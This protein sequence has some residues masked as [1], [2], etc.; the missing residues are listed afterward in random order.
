M[1]LLPCNRNRGA[2]S[3]TLSSETLLPNSYWRVSVDE[4]RLLSPPFFAYS[5]C[6]FTYF[7]LL[8]FVE[9]SQDPLFII[10]TCI[11]FA[12]LFY[13]VSHL[14]LLISFFVICNACIVNLSLACYYISLFVFLICMSYFVTQLLSQLS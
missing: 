11:Q 3:D 6:F 13:F 5:Y 10:L 4:P 14:H 7:L 1:T 8:Y 12:T 9:S 2:P